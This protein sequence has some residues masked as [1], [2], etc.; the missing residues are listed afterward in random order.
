LFDPFFVR[1]HQPTEIGVNLT[2]CYVIVH[3]H[4][5]TINAKLR[6]PRGL[7]IEILIPRDS[8]ATPLTQESFE[9]RLREHEERWR[10]RQ[11]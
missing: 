9:D 4:Q 8:S 10:T 5:G 2:A 7:E 6:E 11:A 3:L 1:S